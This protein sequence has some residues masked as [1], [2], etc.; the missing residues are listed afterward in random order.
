MHS[1]LVEDA[2]YPDTLWLQEMGLGVVSKNLWS[3]FPDPV[4]S[5]YSNSSNI[6]TRTRRGQV[7]SQSDL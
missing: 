1:Q 3:D 4:T 6:T 2:G 5:Y 7:Q